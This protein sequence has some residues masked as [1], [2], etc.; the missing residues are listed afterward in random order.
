MQ[1]NP[2]KN[3]LESI[4]KK[5]K[6][7][8]RWQQTRSSALKTELNK[9]TAQLRTQI[10]QFNNYSF[11]TYLAKLTADKFTEYSLWKAARNINKE[12]K[13]NICMYAVIMK[14]HMYIYIYRL[15]KIIISLHCFNALAY[16]TY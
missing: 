14:I 8:R 6:L 16:I 12:I 11:R 13:P 5:R 10:K 15:S 2:K 7:R 1:T 4:H 3:I 9:C